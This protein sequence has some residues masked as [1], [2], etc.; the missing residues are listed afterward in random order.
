MKKKQFFIRVGLLLCFITMLSACTNSTDKQTIESLKKENEQL[1]NTSVS[2]EA[3]NYSSSS[4]ETYS[5]EQTN[6]QIIS[7]N[8]GTP[9]ELITDDGGK[10]EFIVN[11]VTKDPGNGGF[12]TPDGVFF[13]KIDFTIN[14]TGN[15]PVTPNVSYFDF[16]D[17]NN[18][19]SEI[20][21][22]DYFSETIQPGKTANGTTYFDVAND[23]EDFE[24][25]YSD[26]SWK[27]KY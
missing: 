15:I 17:S 6:S 26:V 27:G 2:S 13:A 5:D 9:I 12:Y 20:N 1:K 8:I 22:R 25:F 18:V 23:G 14:N 24:L 7:G 11:S 19:K 16:Y 4:Y 10:F 21:S 3:N